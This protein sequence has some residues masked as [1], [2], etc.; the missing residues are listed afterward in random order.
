MIKINRFLYIHFSAIFLFVLCYLN[1]NL[2]I[3]AISYTSIFLHELAH[4]FAAYCIGLR[5][6]HIVL[7]AFGVNLK[8]KTTL[9]YNFADELILYMSGPLINAL[10][11]IISMKF[12]ETGNL[13][14][15]LYWNNLMLFLFNLLPIGPMDGGTI[16]KKLLCRK[17]GYKEGNVI[18]NIISVLIITGLIIIEVFLIKISKFNFS[19]V[20]I[21][22]FLIGNIF[23]NKEKYNNDFTK[24]LLFYK[25]KND[26]QIKPVR[27]FLVKENQNYREL[28][29]KFAQSKHYVV[30]I[31]N[32]AGKI[33][34][35]LTEKEIIERILNI[36]IS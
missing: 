16:L 12:T 30:L 14:K 32:N 13:W 23:T 21:C 10:I 29:K 27:A 35:I 34:E 6:S 7:Y 4:M 28:A 26:K 20:F 22:V 17:I 1:R 25:N 15:Y 8:L 2:E 3:L 31:E 5:S 11:A 18:I 19:I 9:L 24:E 33:N 36:S